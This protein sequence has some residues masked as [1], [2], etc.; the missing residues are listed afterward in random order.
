MRRQGE[1][2]EREQRQDSHAEG[3]CTS[4]REKGKGKK[5]ESRGEEDE[6]DEEGGRSYSLCCLALAASV[7]FSCK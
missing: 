7:S 6:G 4:V 3:S 5:E 1:R 2:G